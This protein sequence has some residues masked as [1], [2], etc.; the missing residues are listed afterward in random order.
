[1]PESERGP[2][3]VPVSGPERNPPC[4][5][6]RPDWGF[7]ASDSGQYA[8]VNLRGN[9]LLGDVVQLDGPRSTTGG[10]SP[11]SDGGTVDVNRLRIALGRGDS[12]ASYLDLAS[13]YC[14]PAGRAAEA[15][16]IA[17]RKPPPPVGSG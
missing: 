1:M 13:K 10:D 3:R 7:I 6:G 11:I 12:R 14:R 17:Q 9:T 15:G 4:Y 2:L 8:P 5:G 16:M